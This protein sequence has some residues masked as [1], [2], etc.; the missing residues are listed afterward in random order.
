M[1][2]VQYNEYFGFT[3]TE[4]R[5]TLEYFGFMEKYD[6]IREWYN[7]YQFGELS[8]YCPWDVIS[9]CHALKMNPSSIPQNYWVNTSSNDVIQRFIALADA[10]T[11]DE[12]EL[13]INQGHV[14]KKIRQELTYRDLD[15]KTDNQWSILFT[16]GYLTR[17]GMDS[18]GL[19]ELGIPNKEILWIFE[20]QIQEWFETETQ[21]TYRSL[22]SSA[23]HLRKITQ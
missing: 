19:T 12:I 16:T 20:E 22:K 23:G 6:S 15:S 4:V 21:K 1:N 13:L 7:G 9:Y 8:I 5:A 3:D 2:D 14:K 17:F 10:T 18:R 11:R